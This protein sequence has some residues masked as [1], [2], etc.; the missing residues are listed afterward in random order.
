M[1]YDIL[2]SWTEV[3]LQDHVFPYTRTSLESPRR[4]VSSGYTA[5]IKPR[6]RYRHATAYA[7]SPAAKLPWLNLVPAREVCGSRLHP[8]TR[9]VGRI[10]RHTSTTPTLSFAATF[11]AFA[12]L[13]VDQAACSYEEQAKEQ[14]HVG[15]DPAFLWVHH[16]LIFRRDVVHD[17][18]LHERVKGNYSSIV[19]WIVWCSSRWH[20]RAAILLVDSRQRWWWWTMQERIRGW[21]MNSEASDAIVISM[22]WRAKCSLLPVCSQATFDLCRCLPKD[23]KLCHCRARMKVKIHDRI[24]SGAKH[25]GDEI[26][27]EGFKFNSVSSSLGR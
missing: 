22:D 6:W 25:S 13:A 18:V 15:S 17:C 26:C 19:L 11:Q 2:S 20:N 9:I 24:T 5:G 4:D 27:Q 21:I 3:D 16:L 1:D 10:H 7:A 12:T 23:L 8:S 14:Q